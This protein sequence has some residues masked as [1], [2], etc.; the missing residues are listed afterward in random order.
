MVNAI[1]GVAVAIGVVAIL[2]LLGLIKAIRVIKRIN[3][4]QNKALINHEKHL[5]GTE[6]A[7]KL[8]KNLGKV[9]MV[10]HHSKKVKKQQKY[11]NAIE[12]LMNDL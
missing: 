10:K 8:A 12:D 4:A 11:Q 9:G 3:Q 7:A 6:S 1:T 2:L 5:N